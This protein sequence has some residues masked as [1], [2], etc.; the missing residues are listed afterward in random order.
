ML[1]LS[2]SL[3]DRLCN[4][5]V[6]KRDVRVE[7]RGDVLLGKKVN[8]DKLKVVHT[9]SLSISLQSRGEEIRVLAFVQQGVL[10]QMALVSHVA[11][12]IGDDVLAEVVAIS[13]AE[14]IKQVGGVWVVVLV[15]VVNLFI[16]ANKGQGLV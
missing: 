1:D 6:I 8:Q 15:K 5:I 11:I 16:L 14:H 7:K 13:R 9:Y 2:I 3:N 10:V 4:V 12:L